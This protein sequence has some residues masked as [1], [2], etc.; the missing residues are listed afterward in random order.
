MTLSL[1][2]ANALLLQGSLALS[3]I[4]QNGIKVDTKYLDSMMDKV[5]GQIKRTEE[6]LRKDPV[7]TDTWKKAYGDRTTLGSREQLA[8]VLFDKLKYPSAGYTKGSEALLQEDPDAK[9]RYRADEEAFS[10]ID[11][12][13]VKKWLVLEKLKKTKGTYL[14][15]IVREVCNGYLHPSYALNLARSYRSSSS[16]PN[17]QNLPIRDPEQ[18][19]MIRR[20]FIPRKG[21]RLVE[22][23]YS[24][25]EV[26]VAYCYHKDPV[27]REY[28]LDPTKDMH[29]DSAAKCY[30]LKPDQVT[31]NIRY[32]GKNMFV[33]PQFYGSVFFQCAP[34][35]WA[36]VD[37][38]KLTLTDGTPLRE[39]L[40][41]KGIEELGKCQPGVDPVPGT[42]EHHLKKVEQAFWGPGG[43]QV[44]SNWK[45]SWWKDYQASGE[46]K[47]LTG[48]RI[49]GVMKRNEV[50]NYPVQGSAFHCLLWSIIEIQ[51][52]LTVCGMRTL[53]VGQIH[54]SLLADVPE[55]ELQLYL[56]LAR[57]IMT[58]NLL[59]AWDWISIPLD[60]ECEV[61]PTGGS[62]F[63]KKQW[64]CDNG[65]AWGPKE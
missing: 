16:N 9:A 1:S 34:H 22:I 55:E 2:D 52:Q 51:K 10:H 32:C 42:F 17:F 14:E 57:K 29:R 35:L 5:T 13:F 6:E 58:K 41:K 60:V 62:W 43:F 12:P 30:L 27:M 21:R 64:V 18:G 8:T 61:T 49:S 39:H 20:C 48:F 15:G 45:K 63:S 23:D 24:Q 3:R 37:K 25:I 19:E 54:D 28:L 65:G 46:F 53:L 4:E 38:M 50:I 26:K 44:Y 40:R 36:A 7:F 56:T 47:T 33:F 59:K 31:K 11:S